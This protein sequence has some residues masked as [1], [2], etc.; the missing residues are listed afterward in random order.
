MRDEELQ[1]I[2]QVTAEL[3]QIMRPMTDEECAAVQR[4]FDEI[5]L[6]HAARLAAEKH[7]DA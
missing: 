6:E 2:R 1:R 7:R 4:I 5:R 3:Q